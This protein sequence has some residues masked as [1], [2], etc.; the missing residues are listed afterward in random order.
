VKVIALQ[1]APNGPAISPTYEGVASATYP[2]SRLTYFNVNK[3]PGE[4][5][6]P[7]VAEFLHFIL[8]RQGQAIVR[9]QGIYMPLRGFQAS[10]SLSLLGR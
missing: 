1:A 2:L 4:P 6:D 3:K 8:S 5:L 7:A 9:D 10:R